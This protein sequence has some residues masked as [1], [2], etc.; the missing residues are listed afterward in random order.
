MKKQIACSILGLSA[1]AVSVSAS[2]LDVQQGQWS[3]EL[4]PTDLNISFGSNKN[5][6]PDI[7]TVDSYS[8]SSKRFTFSGRYGYKENITIGLYTNVSLYNSGD[9]L[10]TDLGE[11]ST[12]TY[13]FDYSI[14]PSFEYALMNNFALF[15]AI[16]L[17]FDDADR[18]VDQDGNESYDGNNKLTSTPLWVGGI[19]K[20]DVKEN[21]LFTSKLYAGLDKDY[22]EDQIDS[23]ESWETNYVRVNFLN[24]AHYFLANNFSVNAGLGLY[25]GYR[26]SGKT[27]GIENDFG[28]DTW[29]YQN[30]GTRFGFT[31]YHR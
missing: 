11:T 19:Y 8:N 9:K 14:E 22:S 27:N 23:N 4:Q 31:Y 20:N 26:A 15:G 12:T 17:Y 6:Y 21:I 13:D 5:E 7:N 3:V 16:N 2:E 25:A 10:T 30:F 1:A 28:N 18:T 24:D 29:S